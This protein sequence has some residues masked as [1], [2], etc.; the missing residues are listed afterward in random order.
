MSD[1]VEKQDKW[2]AKDYINNA[3]F[4]PQLS[5]VL[6][7]SF[8]KPSM[9][10]VTLDIGCGDGAL[11][12]RIPCSSIYGIDASESLLEETKKYPNLKDKTFFVDARQLNSDKLFVQLGRVDKQTGEPLYFDKVV[13]NATLH[14]VLN[15]AELNYPS[16]A[17]G[18]DEIENGKELFA[19]GEQVR[20]E[21][22]N[23]VFKLLKPN[24]GSVFAAEMGGLGNVGEIHSAFVAVYDRFTKKSQ[25]MAHIYNKVSPWYF[26][27]EDTIQKYLETAGFKVEKIERVYRSTL[28]PHG[29]DK[30]LRSWLKLFGFN[31]LKA[32]EEYRASQ[33]NGDSLPTSEDYLDEVFDVLKYV[34][35]DP[36]D[37]S[38]AYA[39]YVRLRWRAIKP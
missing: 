37:P 29:T 24:N 8:L 11:T 30:G 21:F 20:Q 19:K 9:S 34:C 1:G 5:S 17:I 22:F 14:W 2:S 13:S 36:R 39:G 3:A 4:V 16:S 26:P 10:D 28:L 27:H 31:F 6:I 25:S 35:T 38:S 15:T 18:L 32:Y 12:T 33:P 7:D 23:Q